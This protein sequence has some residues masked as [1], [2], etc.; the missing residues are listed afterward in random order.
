MAATLTISAI[1]EDATV[2]GLWCCTGVTS[3]A[4]AAANTIRCG[5]QPRYIMVFNVD[6]GTKDEWVNFTSGT[7]WHTAANGTVTLAQ[8]NGVTLEDGTGSTQ[9]ATGSATTGSGFILGTSVLVASKNYRIF[10]FH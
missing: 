3:S 10:A 4:S 6:D 2:Q 7:T 5:F 8:T 9:N 1:T